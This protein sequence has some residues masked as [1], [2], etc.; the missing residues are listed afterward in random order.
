MMPKKKQ[1]QITYQEDLYSKSKYGQQ[2][3]VEGLKV[4]VVMEVIEVVN[5][6]YI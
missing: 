5:V 1:V 3:V 6:S 2:D 4:V